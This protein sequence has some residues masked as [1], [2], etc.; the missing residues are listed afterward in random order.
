[1][2]RDRRRK[3]YGSIYD[4]SMWLIGLVENLLA[5]TRI[6][7]GSR[8]T[9]MQPEL[10][11][12]VFREATAHM[13]RKAENHSVSIRLDDELLMAY[14]DARLVVQVLINLL[15]NAVKYTPPGSHIELSARE[16][17]TSSLSGSPMTARG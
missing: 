8:L 16:T 14:M 10:L 7:A 9:D 12:D 5:I 4:D 3:L 6:E 11:D 13:D 1:M 2:D 17:E 15:N